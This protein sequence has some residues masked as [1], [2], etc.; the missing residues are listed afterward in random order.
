MGWFLS[1]T[2]A[3]ADAA[4]QAPIR[5]F[6]DCNA[7]DF[8]FMR[9]E[10]EFVDYVR[11]RKDADVHVLVTT[12]PTGGG[13]T[14]YVFQFIGLGRFAG[15]D[16]ELRFATQQTTTREERRTGYT[17]IFKLGLV[18][19]VTSTSLADHLHLTYR[20]KAE[21]G[22][23]P[24][25]Q[26]DPWNLW[27]FRLRGSGS[28]NGERSSSSRSF[29]TSFS[30]NR[31]SEQW[32][33]NSGV[34]LNFRENSY[35]LSS[36]GRFVDESHDHNASVLLVKSLGDHWAAAVRGRWSS[37]T[38]LNQDLAVRAAAGIE[39]SVFPYRVSARK[40]LTSQLTFGV[41]HLDYIER[42]IY[43]KDNETVGDA[44]FLTR[45]NAQQPWGSTE[46]AFQVNTYLHDPG[47][48]RLELD[49]GLDIR[50][51]RGFSLNMNGSTSRIRDQLYL[52]AG[53][54]TDE[55]ILL[56]R[57]QLATGY[58]YRFSLGFSYTFGSIFNNIVNTRF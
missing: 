58:R 51:F 13:G 19:Y 8:D 47:R 20:P 43:G 53:A 52:R 57:R 24:T 22:M 2:A 50:L 27:T 54:A 11:D 18:R 45:F 7:C 30:A 9:R 41:S 33:W 40:E 38:F 23:K 1:G 14:E 55:E 34:N 31:T 21:T 15:L 16:D 36:G 6:L 3:A 37:T 42:T 56:R 35:T 4:R 25:M 39:Y 49:G 29:N 26:D 46:V 17:R 10:V 44:L 48:H 28:V 12:Q 5:V 32:K